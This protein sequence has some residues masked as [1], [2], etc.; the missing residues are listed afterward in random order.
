L[1][2]VTIDSKGIDLM[3]YLE[4]EDFDNI[5]MIAFTAVDGRQQDNEERS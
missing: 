2:L 4:E 3:R 1:P 5:I